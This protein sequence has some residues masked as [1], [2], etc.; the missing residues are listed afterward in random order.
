M[1]RNALTKEY[2]VGLQQAA[3]QRAWRYLE[4]REIQPRNIGV[5][6]RSRQR[7]QYGEARIERLQFRL[8]LF[9][10]QAYL[11]AHATHQIDAAVQVDDVDTAGG[12]VQAIDVLRHQA[13]DPLL[14][15]Q[16]SQ[17]VMRVIRPRCSQAPPAHHAARPVAPTKLYVADKCLMH[18]RGS[19][20][21]DAISVAVVRNTRLGAAAR[22]GQYQQARVTLNEISEPIIAPAAAVERVRH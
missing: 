13:F 22:A 9:A 17:C 5:A 19:T 10:R 7:I 2:D 11:A 8:Q 6:V 1:L 12:L 4:A 3:A 20:L 21:P 14:L 18:H 16:A 15:L